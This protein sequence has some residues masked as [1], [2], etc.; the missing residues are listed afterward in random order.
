MIEF[1]YLMQLFWCYANLF[2][3]CVLHWFFGILYPSP[4]DAFVWV[5][6]DETGLKDGELL[7]DFVPLWLNGLVAAIGDDGSFGVDE[8]WEGVSEGGGFAGGDRNPG[9]SH[10]FAIQMQ[11]LF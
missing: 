1:P 8:L 7:V 6:F 2:W 5:F 10:C 3:F 4:F 11:K 9:K